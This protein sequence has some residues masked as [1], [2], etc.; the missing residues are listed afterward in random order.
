MEITKNMLKLLVGLY[1]L[2]VIVNPILGLTGTINL[3]SI[4]NI[5]SETETVETYSEED[6]ADTY[7]LSLQSSLQNQIEE[8]RI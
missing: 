8:L 4:T 1:I 7:I 3:D 6:I 2:Y 5:I